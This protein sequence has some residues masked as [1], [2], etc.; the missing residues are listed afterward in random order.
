[1]Q[2]NS[3]LVYLRDAVV[4]R[5]RRVLG[6]K[7]KSDVS[8]DV[9]SFSQFFSTLVTLGSTFFVGSF[10]VHSCRCYCIGNALQCVQFF[11]CHVKLVSMHWV[12]VIN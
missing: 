3:C 5:W 1:M 9:F 12:L 2:G 4:L 6:L 7:M 10:V 11:F 8:I